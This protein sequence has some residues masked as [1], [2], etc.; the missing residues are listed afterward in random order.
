MLPRLPRAMPNGEL[1]TEMVNKP[2]EAL[3]KLQMLAGPGGGIGV[4][5]SPAG[6]ALVDTRRNTAFWARIV[7]KGSPATTGGPIPWSWQEVAC[8]ANGSWVDGYRKGSSDTTTMG[9]AY[10]SN[11]NTAITPGTPASGTTASSGGVVVEL[12]YVESC[13]GWYFGYGAC[14]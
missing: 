3:E 12:R 6:T 11:N 4:H 14:S 5:T 8:S 13:D 7:G 1:T 9:P 2:S 10:E